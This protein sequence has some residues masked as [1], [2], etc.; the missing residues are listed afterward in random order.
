MGRA[1]RGGRRNSRGQ[2]CGLR[3]QAAHTGCAIRGVRPPTI[4]ALVLVMCAARMQDAGCARA[5]GALWGGSQ[6]GHAAR[7]GATCVWWFAESEEGDRPLPRCG[8]VRSVPRP[9]VEGGAWPQPCGCCACRSDTVSARG[10]TRLAHHAGCNCAP[11]VRMTPM[12]APRHKLAAP[13]VATLSN[14]GPSGVCIALRPTRRP[15]PCHP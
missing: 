13:C 6:S 10:Q 5:A 11:D 9:G 2:C 7:H 14:S 12:F 4:A 15:R 1:R 3:P 8:F